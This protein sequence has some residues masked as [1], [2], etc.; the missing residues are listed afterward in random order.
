MAGG[1]GRGEGTGEGRMASCLV[2][3]GSRTSLKCRACF[4]NTQRAGC[5]ALPMSRMLRN[6]TFMWT[7]VCYRTDK[8][9]SSKGRA[10]QSTETRT[11]RWGEQAGSVE[12]LMR[13]KRG[14]DGGR[15][16]GRPT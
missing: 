13:S 7:D 1:G 10:A 15:R 16:G 12:Q 4:G 14:G 8:P 3:N 9:Q 11:L 2:L 5:T 6:C